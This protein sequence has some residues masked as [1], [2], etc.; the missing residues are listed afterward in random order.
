MGVQ[1]TK[2]NKNKYMGGK[3]K[4]VEV[5]GTKYVFFTQ[6]YLNKLDLKYFMTFG[7][8]YLLNNYSDIYCN[9][10]FIQIICTFYS[11]NF[12]KFK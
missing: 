3:I 9:F 11:Q 4:K 7:I 10:I 12:Q 2:G 1:W 5:H 8:L 6:N